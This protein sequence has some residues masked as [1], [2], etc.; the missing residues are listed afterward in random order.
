MN[1]I[2]RAPERKSVWSLFNDLDT[3]FDEWRPAQRFGE[4][5]GSWAPAVDITET[6]N[7]YHVV[8]DLPGVKKEDLD[9]T[10]QDGVLTINAE[11]KYEKE[12]REEGRLLRQ[13]RRY[14]K[15]V[16]SMRLGSDVDP[17]NIKA[18]YKDGVLDLHLP[19]HEQVKPKK[20][21][22]SVA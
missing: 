2:I 12:E 16:R 22:V 7:E 11:S 5:G 17:D 3:L 15:F 4:E 19:K 8:A 18:E 6:E 13:E 10:I 9:V 1:S 21:D 20:V 14:G